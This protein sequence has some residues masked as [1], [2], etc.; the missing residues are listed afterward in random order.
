MRSYAAQLQPVVSSTVGLPAG[1][2]AG[3]RM[4]SWSGDRSHRPAILTAR[5]VGRKGCGNACR[6]TS[7]AHRAAGGP[8]VPDARSPGSPG[9]AAQ[10]R[11]LQ[12]LLPDADAGAVGAEA[13]ARFRGGGVVLGRSV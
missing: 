13:V 4:G 3:G 5:S 6:T 7:V 1:N 12:R 10:P 9:R 11:H 2:R 8:A